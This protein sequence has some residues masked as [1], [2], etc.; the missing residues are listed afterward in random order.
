VVTFLHPVRERTI[1]TPEY[2]GCSVVEQINLFN[3]EEVLAER[4]VSFSKIPYGDYFKVR[5]YY[6]L[7]GAGDKCIL[8]YGF[9]V[10]FV[11]KTVWSGKIESTTRAENIDLWKE[12]I[13][14]FM[15]R[16]ATK[17]KENKNAEEIKEEDEK[18]SE[19]S[20]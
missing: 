14:P 2:A 4:E 5:T 3:E 12:F 19:I 9:C 20:R 17:I 16:E 8:E 13:Q 1:L 11:K 7:K 18:T 6:Y 15:M 10:V